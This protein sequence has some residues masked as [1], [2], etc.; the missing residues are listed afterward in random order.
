MTRIL[1]R[2]RYALCLVGVMLLLL[3]AGCGK[4]EQ[5]GPSP[6]RAQ[7]LEAARLAHT[8]FERNIL[9]DGRI[10]RAEY[11]SAEQRFM[12]CVKA[13]GVAIAAEQKFGTY[14]YVTSGDGATSDS[15]VEKCSTGTTYYIEALYN[16][17]VTNP[18]QQDAI[19]IRVR[20]LVKSGLA[21]AGYT[22]REYRQASGADGVLHLPFS[23][24]DPRF[25]ECMTNPQTH[26]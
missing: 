1:S 3:V 24:T 12:A 5:S 17:T 9:K 7:I 18:Q 6:Y 20:C 4:A 25:E 8:A 19:V 26:K 11:V 14:T 21:P 15:V 13:H 22:A 16:E 2:W 10:T 23:D